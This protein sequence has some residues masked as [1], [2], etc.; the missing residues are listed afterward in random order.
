M[1]SATNTAPILF[2]LICIFLSSLDLEVG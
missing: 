2:L 1:R